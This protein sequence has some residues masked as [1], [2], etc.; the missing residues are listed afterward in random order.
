M[1]S[2]LAS[3]LALLLVL[4]PT[5]LFATRRNDLCRLRRWRMHNCILQPWRVL[6]DLHPAPPA[7]TSTTSP[8]ATARQSSSRNVDRSFTSSGAK[9]CVT[10]TSRCCSGL[11]TC[12][13]PAAT[14]L[15]LV[16]WLRCCRGVPARSSGGDGALLDTSAPKRGWGGG[17]CP[18]CGRAWR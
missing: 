11:G 16:P 8:S 6:C 2:S 13:P 15:P 12:W 7:S 5:F 4:L 18:S 9:R 10:D 3:H 17:S 14:R 1:A